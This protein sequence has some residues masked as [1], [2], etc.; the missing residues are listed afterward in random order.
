MAKSRQSTEDNPPPVHSDEEGEETGES[1]A[2][3]EDSDS[4]SESGEDTGANE[5]TVANDLVNLKNPRPNPS[6]TKGATAGSKRAA[7]KPPSVNAKRAKTDNSGK[8]IDGNDEKMRFS[9]IFSEEDEIAILEGMG[10]FSANTK[11]DPFEKKNEFYEFI[12]EKIG[13]DIIKGQ[14]IR[15]MKRLREKYI[16]KAEKEEKKL[17]KG[18]EWILS[19]PH[20]QSLYTLSKK[21]WGNER[22]VGSTTVVIDYEELKKERKKEKGFSFA[23]NDGGLDANWFLN[24]GVK[25]M[26]DNDRIAMEK[27]WKEFKLLECEL[28]VKERKLMLEHMEKVHKGIKSHGK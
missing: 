9:R 5:D 26:G 15:K 8:S 1:E 13:G 19:N 10:V 17:Q 24:E 4:L 6:P 28:S 27:K 18:K 21:I 23:P 12:K 14:L 3:S 25:L 22:E 16:N 20:E 11:S 2:E 7:T